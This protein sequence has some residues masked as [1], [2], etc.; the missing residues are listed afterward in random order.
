M[1][2][3]T[4]QQ[5][6]HRMINFDEFVAAQL[7]LDKDL[8][9]KGFVA[10]ELIST[11][12]G[13]FAR[14][15]TLVQEVEHS[16]CWEE[17]ACGLLSA[18]DP[19]QRWRRRAISRDMDCI[20]PRTE[21]S[22]STVNSP[23]PAERRSAGTFLE[24]LIHFETQRSACADYYEELTCKRTSC[25]RE[26]TSRHPNLADSWSSFVGHDPEEVQHTTAALIPVPRTLL[27][28]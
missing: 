10:P 4:L 7:R 17:H 28:K 11:A 6:L 1:A 27:V 8:P 16:A 26:H 25:N 19:W 22:P 18:N 24:R 3:S 2:N 20:Q 13:S 9:L 14:T 23:R 15:W 12:V 5:L 21:M